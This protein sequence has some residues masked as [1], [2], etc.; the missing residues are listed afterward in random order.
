MKKFT[1]KELCLMA[2]FTALI[3]AFSQL[4][5]PLPGGVPMTL[6][7]YIIPVAGI[8]LGP[9]LG[10]FA[11]LVYILLGAAGAPVF[12][13]FS[14]GFAAIAGMTGGFLVSFPLMA[15]LAGLGDQAGRKAG[16]A[17]RVSYYSLLVLFLIAGTKRAIPALEVQR[18]L[19]RKR[20][21]PVWEMMHKLRDV[22]GKR[23]GLCRLSDQVEL[24]EGFFTTETP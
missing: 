20:Y 14:G 22:T 19:G 9:Q 3:S 1:T 2:V 5:V 13:N 4:S 10:F 17:S 12:A 8:V 6:Q 23:D 11:A 21:Q 16:E 7:T 15:L 24:D 18:Q